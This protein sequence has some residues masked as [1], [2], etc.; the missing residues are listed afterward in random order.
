MRIDYCDICGHQAGGLNLSD[1]F[2]RIYRVSAID[3][4]QYEMTLCGKCNKRAL[5][6]IAIES[7]KDW[8]KA[9]KGGESD[10]QVRRK[11]NLRWWPFV[12]Q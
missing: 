1:P 2:P 3:G 9:I 4:D 11:K 7:K 5:N 12:R 8:E 6:L 10:E